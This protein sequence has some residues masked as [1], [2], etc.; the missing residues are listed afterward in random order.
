MK[1]DF[2]RYCILY[3]H[4]G[5]YL[6]IKTDAREQIRKIF[7]TTKPKTWYTVLSAVKNT[8][9]NGI[10]ATPP[11]NPIIKKAIDHIYSNPKPDHYSFYIE[12]LYDIIQEESLQPLKPGK[13]YQ[14]NGWTCILYQE[15]CV[16]CDKGQK[17]C[18]RYN[19]QCKIA[20]SN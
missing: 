1:A 5:I 9:H 15:T 11:K 4:G 8:I 7:G 6:D 13:N 20:T 2:W 16:K 3:V 10:I 18:D 12:S 17:D 14:K 19:L